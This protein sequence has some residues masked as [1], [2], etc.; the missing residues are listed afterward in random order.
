MLRKTCLPPRTRPTASCVTPCPHL[1]P[2]WV[3]P[4]VLTALKEEPFEPLQSVELKFFSLKTVLLNALASV[5]RVED[6]QAFSV[7]DLCLEFGPGN[8]H[9][10]LRPWPG[11]VPKVPTTHFRDQVLN[12]QAL[13]REEA[14]PA[15]PLLCPVHP[16]VDHTQ[17]FRT[18]DQLYVCFGGQ[19]KEKAVSKQRLAHW[20]VEAIVLAYHARRLP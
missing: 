2:S 19:Q 10:V 8:S 17:S 6:L 3:L 16:F 14:D 13:P 20:I 15:I 18:S 11:C 1:V 9:V 4:S 5:K 12:L 7:N